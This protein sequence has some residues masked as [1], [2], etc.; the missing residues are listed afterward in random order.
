[1]KESLINYQE[2]VK[3]ALKGVFREILLLVEKNGL[4]G[5]QHYYITFKTDEDGVKIPKRLKTQYPNEMT[6][7][8]QHRFWDFKVEKNHFEIGLSFN[9][10][11]EL[12]VIPYDAVTSLVDPSERFA[13]Q[14]DEPAEGE[15]EEAGKT[16]PNEG[17]PS[18]EKSPEKEDTEKVVSIDAF[19]K[20]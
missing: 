13:L 5:E 14:F 17:A 9:Q 19:R 2:L 4:Q 18:G 10:K 16:I 6:I 12:L 11:P 8:I 20:N 15:E 7:V 3:G 1:M